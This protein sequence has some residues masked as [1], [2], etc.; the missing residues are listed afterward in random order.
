[1]TPQPTKKTGTLTII[2]SG[3]LSSSMGK[4][5][6]AILARIAEPVNAVFLDTPAGFEL[7]V[8][9][10]TEKAVA[11]FEL[12]LQM[13]LKPVSFKSAL[14]AKPHDMKTIVNQLRAADFILAGPGSP[15][16]TVRNLRDT[17][18]WDAISCRLSEGAHLVV[19]SAAAIAVGRYSLPVYEIYKVGESPHWTEGLDLLGP[20][21]LDLAIVPHWNNAEGG[22]HDT[23]YCFMGGS[24]LAALEQ[25]LPDTTTVL[26]VDEYTAC[27]LDLANGSGQVMGA[28]K[29]TIRRRGSEVVFPAG[30]VFNLDQLCD[31]Q[32]QGWRDAA[33]EVDGVPLKTPIDANSPM[34]TSEDVDNSVDP[35]AIVSPFVD[36]LVALRTQLREEEQWALADEIRQQLLGLSVVLEDGPD[37]TTW[38]LD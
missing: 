17:A 10:I 6:R 14:A 12:R 23:R 24:R 16:Y 5:Y 28:G 22:T 15:T 11:Y 13:Q 4:A 1:M 25:L 18:V 35:M 37:Q 32:Q 31:D 38:R 30:A 20:Y 34:A 29:V 27:I 19:A 36:L 2:G 8:D 21:G 26:G 7:N 33:S 3:E 9:H